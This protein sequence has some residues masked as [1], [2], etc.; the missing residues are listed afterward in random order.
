VV[1]NNEVGQLGGGLPK[2]LDTWEDGDTNPVVSTP[3]MITNLTNQGVV[4]LSVGLDHNAVLTRVGK[5]SMWGL[6]QEGQC[7]IEGEDGVDVTRLRVEKISQASTGHDH[8]LL[9]TPA[10][11]VLSFGSNSTGQLG[12]RTA[13]KWDWRARPVEG[14]SQVTYIAAGSFHNLALDRDG[15]LWSWGWAEGGRLGLGEQAE[16]VT[17][18][19][20]VMLPGDPK[21]RYI[22]AGA[23]HNVIISEE[24]QAF[25]WGGSEH[26]QLGL[27][28]E[29]AQLSPVVLPLRNEAVGACLG[30]EH[31]F[32]LVKP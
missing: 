21:I 29:D 3:R 9:L 7:G 25:V 27:S 12:R 1:G 30:Q 8:T 20:Q 26:N 18:P 31:T 22:Y 32:I 28:T 6:N 13:E 4:G 15:N 5:V 24:G 16:D 14:L 19:R 2:P 10:G 17:Q 23:N 11:S